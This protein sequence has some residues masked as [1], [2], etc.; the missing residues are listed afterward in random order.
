MVSPV[1]FG[2]QGKIPINFAV[3][4]DIQLS[5]TL[6]QHDRAVSCVKF[7][8][9]GTLLASCSSDKTIKV[10]AL[11]FVVYF[12]ANLMQSYGKLLPENLFTFY[13]VTPWE[14]RMLVG[15][16]TRDI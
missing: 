3:M 7:S 15:L 8:S 1:V 14:Y 5:C 12:E 4:E 9:D 11:T 16:T 2:W 6:N 10:Y 13:V